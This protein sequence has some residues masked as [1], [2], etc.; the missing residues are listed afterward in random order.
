MSLLLS[1]NATKIIGYKPPG[2][3]WIAKIAGGIWK[4]KLMNKNNGWI[5]R[6]LDDFLHLFFLRELLN[7]NVAIY[8]LGNNP[9]DLLGEEFPSSNLIDFELML[10]LTEK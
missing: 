2:G 4:R 7:P 10:R 8:H 1:K 5:N 3:T 9:D 6:K